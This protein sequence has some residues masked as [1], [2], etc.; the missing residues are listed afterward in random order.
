[1]DNRL[2]YDIH[3]RIF[4]YISDEERFCNIEAVL[5]ADSDTLQCEIIRLWK[6]WAVEKVKEFY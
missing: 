5:A 2:C 6:K 3:K 4:K 1:M